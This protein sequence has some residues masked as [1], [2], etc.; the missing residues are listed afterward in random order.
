[1][2]K[3]WN[4]QKYSECQLVTLWNAAM[5]YGIDVPTQYGAEYKMECVRAKAI[6]GAAIA[7]GHLINKLGLKAING[8]LNWEWIKT[9]CPI[10]FPIFCY[11]GYHSVL[12]VDVNT[13]KKRV[14]LTNYT[15]GKLCWVSI[16]NLIKMHNKRVRPI[17][18]V[19]SDC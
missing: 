3:F 12:M 17:K 19:I 11:R 10:E 16:D 5:Y 8:R 4:D 9:N 18:W 1:M 7:S 13:V 15:K 2:T 6:H 14:L